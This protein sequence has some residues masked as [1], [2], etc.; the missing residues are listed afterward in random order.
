MRRG[1]SLGQL[2]PSGR[3]TISS[4]SMDEEADRGLRRSDG[5]ESIV[6]SLGELLDGPE[7]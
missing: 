2:E 6:Q 5:D 3:L 7:N 1:G 4:E